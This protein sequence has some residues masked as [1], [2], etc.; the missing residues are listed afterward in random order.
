MANV[1]EVYNTVVT[2][3]FFYR[4]GVVFMGVLLRPTVF[5][6]INKILFLP[7]LFEIPFF[8][9]YFCMEGTRLFTI[10]FYGINGV[11]YF[12]YN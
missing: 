5:V 1:V 6:Q 12:V 2:F 9:N 4:C 7:H 11:F 8:S 3:K 10:E